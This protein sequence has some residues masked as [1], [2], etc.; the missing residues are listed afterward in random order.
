MKEEGRVIPCAFSRREG[1]GP[2]AYKWYIGRNIGS[3]ETARIIT[4]D[5][6]SC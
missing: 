2:F 3:N 4:N 6:K 1:R 5:L